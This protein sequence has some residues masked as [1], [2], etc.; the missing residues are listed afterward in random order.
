SKLA[1]A[2]AVQRYEE[3]LLT[4]KMEVSHDLKNTRTLSDRARHCGGR[5]GAGA[6]TIGT[7]GVVPSHPRQDPG[8]RNQRRVVLRHDCHPTAV[9]R[10]SGEYPDRRDGK[11]RYLRESPGDRRDRRHCS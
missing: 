11:K 1:P 7:V 3:G 5:T 8:S 6:V 2:P 4:M 9:I 10:K